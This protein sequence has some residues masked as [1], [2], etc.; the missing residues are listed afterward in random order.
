MRKKEN[1]GRLGLIYRDVLVDVDGE[2]LVNIEELK[3][4]PFVVGEIQYGKWMGD[5][6]RTY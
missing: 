4:L 3:R 6:V 1:D 5:W 2:K